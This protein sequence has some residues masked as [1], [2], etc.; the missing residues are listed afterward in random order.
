MTETRPTQ[1]RTGPSPLAAGQ[2]TLLLT[3][4]TERTAASGTPA[5]AQ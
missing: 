5:E 3:A 2:V 4:G 1:R